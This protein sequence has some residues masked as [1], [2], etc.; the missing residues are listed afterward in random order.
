MQKGWEVA[1]LIDL[2]FHKVMSHWLGYVHMRPEDVN[3]LLGLL[4]AFVYEMATTFSLSDR[5]M[6]A[7]QKFFPADFK[8][9]PSDMNTLGLPRQ[10][11]ALMSWMVGFTTSI[12]PRSLKPMN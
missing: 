5:S 12:L 3:G 7:M 4:P 8:S 11:A 6:A 10:R 2:S 1:G 9:Y